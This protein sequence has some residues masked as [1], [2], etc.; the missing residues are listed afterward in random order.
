MT[1]T[2]FDDAAWQMELRTEYKKGLPKK[3]STLTRLVTCLVEHPED[4]EAFDALCTCVHKIR[5]SA[6]SFGLDRLS[7]AAAEWEQ[8]LDLMLPDPS[9]ALGTG[10]SNLFLQLERLRECA[11]ATPEA[12]PSE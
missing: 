4:R 7:Q 2:E 6:G 11:D 3:F 5:G 9:M 12:K 10:S 1:D 8:Q